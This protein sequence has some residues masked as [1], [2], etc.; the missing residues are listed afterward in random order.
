MLHLIGA[1]LSDPEDITVK[2]LRKIQAADKVYLEGYT[3]K[4]N[5]TKNE[6]EAF[7][8][9]PIHVASREQLEQ[10][11]TEILDQ[12]TKEDVAVVVIG[13]VFSATTHSMLFV[14]AK[15]R[16]IDVDIVHNASIINAVSQTGL[17]LYKFGKT[18]SIVYPDG[19]WLP[20]T[21]YHAIKD[22]QEKD[23]HTLCLLDIQADS[24]GMSDD[25]DRFMTA[26]EAVTVLRR[27]ERKEQDNVI[28][29][30][31]EIIVVQDLTGSA[32]NL[33]RGTISTIDD[34]HGEQPL[35]SLIIPG[36]MHDMEDEMVDI[37]TQS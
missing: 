14:E 15:N 11:H 1:G 22:N 9:A 34:F 4:L 3:S 5:T 6:L 32:Q 7:Y 25:N 20:S 16:G 36:S 31:T 18:T 24:A 13:D 28:Q 21:P 12:A 29:D 30:D 10:G 35:H 2:G 8:E 26:E 23:L 17:Q 33:W 19:D 37:V 27:L